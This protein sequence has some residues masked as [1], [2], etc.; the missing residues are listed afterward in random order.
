MGIR[1]LTGIAAV[2]WSCVN[3]LINTLSCFRKEIL[4]SVNSVI[5]TR[6][7]NDVRFPVTHWNR[8]TNQHDLKYQDS[9][10]NAFLQYAR[11]VPGGMLAFFPSYG[12][13][14]KIYDRWKVSSGRLFV[15]E[16]TIQ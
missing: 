8:F 16:I 4:C 5:G 3:H 11:V 10:G 7:T 1:R 2:D 13:M 6:V 14:E 12:L 15:R 9:L